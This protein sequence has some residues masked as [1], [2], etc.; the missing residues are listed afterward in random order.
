MA[1]LD[2]LQ[3]YIRGA[4]LAHLKSD[5]EI[6]KHLAAAR[7][8]FEQ[9]K[10]FY[11][12]TESECLVKKSQACDLIKIFENFK[13]EDHEGI[14]RV[15]MRVKLALI[16][17]DL[18]SEA[19]EAIDKGEVVD[20]NWIKSKDATATTS[21]DKE[22]SNASTSE[23][24]EGK[25]EAKQDETD[26]VAELRSKLAEALAALAASKSSKRTVYMLPHFKSN[27]AYLILGVDRGASKA[28]IRKSWKTLM[29]IH[30]PDKC[31]NTELAT[32]I[33]QIVN[34]AYQSV[35]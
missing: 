24:K 14:I 35:A 6:G 18:I 22:D 15:A 12:W 27:S 7:E 34:Q 4:V 19:K 32:E 21:N 25:E 2:Q 20:T 23:K 11:S 26:L 3:G 16:R 17:K 28:V 10:E 13:D 33:T 31:A 30:H 29:G 5:I 8:H 9:A 1:T